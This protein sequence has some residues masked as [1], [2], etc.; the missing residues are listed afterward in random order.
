MCMNYDNSIPRPYVEYST[1]NITYQLERIDCTK[2]KHEHK[3]NQT[4]INSFVCFN[5]GMKRE[6]IIPKSG[7][8]Y[9]KYLSEKGK[10]IKNKE[11]KE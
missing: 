1:D 10:Q 7:N 11:C 4:N 2:V 8:Y 3:W 9:T 6:I 5:C